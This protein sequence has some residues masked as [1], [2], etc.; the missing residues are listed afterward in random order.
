MSDRFVKKCNEV[1]DEKSWALLLDV[2]LDIVS[3]ASVYSDQTAKNL[4]KLIKIR[5]AK[6]GGR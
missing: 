6:V 5:E 1:R 4:E 3:S 2:L